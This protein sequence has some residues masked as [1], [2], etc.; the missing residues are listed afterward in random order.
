MEF[1]LLVRL[2]DDSEEEANSSHTRVT[3]TQDFHYNFS[4]LTTK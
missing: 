4:Y 1:V 2:D 3:F